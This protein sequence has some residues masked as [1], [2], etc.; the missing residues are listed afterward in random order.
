MKKKNQKGFALAETLIVSTVVAGIL[1]YLFVQFSALKRS[2]NNSFNYN[3]V[4]DLYAIEDVFDYIDNLSS[5]TRTNII[6]G[7]NSQDYIEIVKKDNEYTDNLEEEQ[8]VD[9]EYGFNLLNALDIKALII[10]KEDISSIDFDSD[11]IKQGMKTFMSKIKNTD[12]G[13]YRLIAQFENN[14]YS[15]MVI[16][17]EVD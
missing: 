3:S 14:T 4:D 7:I 12:G 16:P 5:E 11:N 2:Y 13:N 6:S 9:D 1:V 8:V 17:V 15:T 10:T